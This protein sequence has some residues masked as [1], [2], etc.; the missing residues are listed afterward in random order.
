MN[1]RSIGQ[2]RL[3]LKITA[4][5]RRQRF[6]IIQ[7]ML[8][9]YD[10]AVHILDVGGTPNYW[11]LMTDGKF[12]SHWRIQLLNLAEIEIAHPNITSTIG[13]GRNMPQFGDNQFDIVLSN[14][15][16]EHVGN[17][18]NQMRMAEEIRRV[19]R[20]Y[21]IQTP[22][23]YFP[24]EAHYI[25]P[26]FQYLPMTL[27]V[28]LVLTLRLGCYGARPK[29][30]QVY[31]DVNNIRLLNRSEFQKLFP[32]STIVHETYCG[33]IKSFVAYSGK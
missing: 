24:I 30:K 29:Y 32:D 12:N 20:R 4:N 17:F 9:D 5:L 1:Y 19:G 31:D 22:N 13:D 14:S 3:L 21:C 16:I 25:F 28:W 26:F 2:N 8:D 33:F 23:R 18:Q 10:G 11:Q 15:T 7:K 6:A 27:Q